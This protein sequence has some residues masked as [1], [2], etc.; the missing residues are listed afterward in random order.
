ML[1]ETMIAMGI[2]AVFLTGQYSANLR[3]WS[4]LRASLESNAASRVL[5]GRTEQIRA[6]TWDQITN[7]AFLNTSVLSVAPDAAGD[8]GA[9]NETID[10]IAYPTPSPNPTALRVTR[11]NDTGTVSTVGAGDGTMNAQT[12]LRIN[13]TETWTA[14]GGQP[15]MKQLSVIVSNGGVIGRH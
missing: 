10:V 1:L 13:L 15:R 12:S 7:A 5:N 6:A 2:V 9:L 4:L 3:V 8:L 14:K 11:N